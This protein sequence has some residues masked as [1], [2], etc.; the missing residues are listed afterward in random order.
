VL[1]PGDDTVAKAMTTWQQATGGDST[2]IDRFLAAPQQGS[3]ISGGPDLLLNLLLDSGNIGL[4]AQVKQPVL[5]NARWHLATSMVA[6]I[7]DFLDKTRYV[8]GDNV[9][10][11]HFRGLEQR[12][13][14][15]RDPDGADMFSIAALQ[16]RTWI[17]PTWLTPLSLIVEV[18]ICRG[19]FAAARRFAS[20]YSAL[21][22]GRERLTVDKYIQQIPKSISV[23]DTPP[24]RDFYIIAHHMLGQGSKSC[25]VELI[26]E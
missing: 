19:R 20:R 12:F 18:L 13:Q 16:L 26:Y 24:S 6:Q 23:C 8:V 14:A 25:E 1:F 9:T 2:A 5:S 21:T 10:I 22:V 17:K 11:E 4:L 15:F 7:Q 3:T